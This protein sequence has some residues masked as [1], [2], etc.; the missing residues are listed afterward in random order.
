ME[1]VYIYRLTLSSSF[2]THGQLGSPFLNREGNARAQEFC[3]TP[4]LRVGN[5]HDN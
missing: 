3:A 1:E 5:D 2:C 4:F